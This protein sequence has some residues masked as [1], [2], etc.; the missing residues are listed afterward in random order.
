MVDEGKSFNSVNP[1]KIHKW[2]MD[3]SREI[4]VSKIFKTGTLFLTI[5]NKCVAEKLLT[6]HIFHGN[7][8]MVTPHRSL[9]QSRGVFYCQDIAQLNN[10]EILK[11]LSDQGPTNIRRIPVKNHSLQSPL[12][13]GTFNQA[14]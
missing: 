7:K 6:Q 8:I 9:N 2:L 13:I 14:E 10:D 3:F 1:F 12:F 4:K 11:E 5:E